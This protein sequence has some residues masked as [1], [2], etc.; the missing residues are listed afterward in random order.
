[1]TTEAVRLA[2][3][4]TVRQALEQLGKDAESFETVYYL[5]VVDGHGSPSRH[6]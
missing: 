1:M 6:C 5:Y 2:E 4:L 3:G